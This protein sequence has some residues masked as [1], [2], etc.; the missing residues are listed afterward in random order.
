M[1]QGKP[2]LPATRRRPNNTTG[3]R[4]I[5]TAPSDCD[6]WLRLNPRPRINLEELIHQVP[7]C[8]PLSAAIV[9]L[10]HGDATCGFYGVLV[11]CGNSC[12]QLDYRRLN[13]APGVTR[14]RDRR[15]RNPMLYPAELQALQWFIKDRGLSRG[16]LCLDIQES[17]TVSWGGR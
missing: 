3:R 17:S 1:R 16:L 7:V 4:P 13:G 5:T 6:V 12:N 2:R 9:P 11:A 8:D 15:I 10:R 14:T